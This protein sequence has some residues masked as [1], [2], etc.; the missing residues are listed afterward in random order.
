MSFRKRNVVLSAGSSGGSPAAAQPQEQRSMPTAALQAA[1][2]APVR[3]AQIVIPQQ[4]QEQE[5]KKEQ[6]HLPDVSTW[7]VSSPVELSAARRAELAPVKQQLRLLLE[8]ERQ[9]RAGIR[10][11]RTA[12]PVAALGGG[13]RPSP[14]DGR[15]ITSTGTASLDVLL[16]G[17]GGLL[18]GHSLLVQEQG[19]TDFAGVLLRAFAAE[20]LVQGHHVH[21]LGFGHGWEAELPGIASTSS[22]RKPVPDADRMKIAWRYEGLSARPGAG[23]SPA[24]PITTTNITPFCHTLDPSRRLG[25]ADIKGTLHP[26]PLPNPLL[27]SRTPEPVHSPLR[28]FLASVRAS[29]EATPPSAVHRVVLPAFLS[30]TLYAMD[31]WSAPYILSLLLGLRSLL[32]EHGR[33]L[34]VMLS[35]STSL[36]DRADYSVRQLERVCDNVVELVPLPPGRPS[37]ASAAASNT[38]TSPADKMQGWFR[39]H[40]LQ[41]YSETGGAGASPQ[42]RALRENFCFS[43]SASRGLEIAPY[44]LP[45]VDDGNHNDKSAPASSTK[46]GIEF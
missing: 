3:R 26:F 46:E 35:L 45:P 41:V 27:P 12:A 1:R 40:K 29:L 18:L 2:G 42:G 17:Y 11:R 30:P 43:M 31:G 10:G 14:F 9:T 5:Q 24:G 32:R 28:A 4:E 20:G 37:A 8:Q 19:T 13:A 6:R 38:P 33:R 36:Y 15:P 16:A 21:V 39:V 22:S 7:T 44:S 23:R 25:P 34:T